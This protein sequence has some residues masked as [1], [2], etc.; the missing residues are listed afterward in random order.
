L[1][2]QAECDG[3]AQ[4][5][6]RRG[7]DLHLRRLPLVQA[8]VVARSLDQAQAIDLSAASPLRGELEHEEAPLLATTVDAQQTPG[9]AVSA[10][11]VDRLK[12]TL[13]PVL[14]RGRIQHGG[15]G[16]K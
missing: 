9:P 14:V 11:D 12:R 7:A 4:N 16:S 2:A 15:P 3:E 13:T 10:L 6:V 5:V 8:A 1:R